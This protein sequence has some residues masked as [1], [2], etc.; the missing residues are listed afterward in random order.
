MT[1]GMGSRGCIV[2]CKFIH[3]H[4]PSKLL[5]GRQQESLQYDIQIDEGH[6]SLLYSRKQ[7]SGKQYF[8][9]Y[10]QEIAIA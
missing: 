2:K 10:A 8:E 5:P 6:F 9:G 1:Q 7:A 3:P 4:H